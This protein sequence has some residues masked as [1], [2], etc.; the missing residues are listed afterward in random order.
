MVADSLAHQAQ[1]GFS[2]F[3]SYTPTPHLSSVVSLF[4]AVFPVFSGHLSLLT[5]SRAYSKEFFG[6]HNFKSSCMM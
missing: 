6:V 3:Q 5:S 4:L 2:C 1:V